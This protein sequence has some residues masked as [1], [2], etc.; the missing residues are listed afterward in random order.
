MKKTSLFSVLFAL[1]IFLLVSCEGNKKTNDKGNNN[2][3]ANTEEVT[4]NNDENVADNTNTVKEEEAFTSDDGSFK[5]NFPKKPKKAVAPV[6]TEAGKVDM[7]TY[8]Y[9]EEAFAYMVAYTDYPSLIIDATEPYSLLEKGKDGFIATM[10]L[11][12]TKENSKSD[13][14]DVPGIYFEAAGNG[15][16]S[17]AQ[18]FL[19]EN[20]LY[21][22]A[23]L[24]GDRAPNE[25]EIKEFVKS[26]EFL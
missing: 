20:R 1:T 16:F 26:F 7:T 22:I 12:I 24:R 9:E 5:I 23:I 18:E 21:Q 10:A 25:K 15:Y 8:M 13:L 4:D 6:E 17:V 3:D 2:D 19:V 14:G 11:E